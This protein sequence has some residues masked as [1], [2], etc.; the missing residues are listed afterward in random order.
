MDLSDD[1][2][3]SAIA[4]LR[5]IGI[6]SAPYL[7]R[8]HHITHELAMAVIEQLSNA[9]YRLSDN[10]LINLKLSYKITKVKTRKIYFYLHESNH[11]KMSY[12]S[13]KERDAE[14]EKITEILERNDVL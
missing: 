4:Q 1:L 6:V 7:Q 13:K 10:Q 8:K 3:I 9:Y 12:V 2:L 5:S 11:F 14:F